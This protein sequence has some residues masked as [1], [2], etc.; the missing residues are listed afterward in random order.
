[1][2]LIVARRTRYKINGVTN[3]IFGLWDHPI[4]SLR[5]LNT[6]KTRVIF[7]IKIVFP[8]KSEYNDFVKR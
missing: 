5:L 2:H 8:L 7:G 6:N 4:V 1:M 3:I